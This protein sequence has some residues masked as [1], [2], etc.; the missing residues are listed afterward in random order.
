MLP[1]PQ[2]R[3]RERWNRTDELQRLQQLEQ[4]KAEFRR[5]V[6]ERRENMA[7]MTPDEK[8]EFLFKLR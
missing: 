4:R 6:E 7:N 1:C 3:Y 2:A 8:E 5:K